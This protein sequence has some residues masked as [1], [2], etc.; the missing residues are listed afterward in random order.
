IE[1]DKTLYRPGEPFT[2]FVSSSEPEQNVTVDVLRDSS[3]IRSQ[4]IK[5]HDGRG[6]VVFTYKPEFNDR[7][8]VVAYGDSRNWGSGI[9]S[10]TILYPKPADLDVKARA[11]Q[12]NYRPGEDA[13]VNVSVRSAE[14]H[15]AESALGVVVFDSAV[16]E[17][18]RTAQEFGSPMYGPASL[19]A[20]FL[21]LEEQVAGVSLRDLSRLDMSKPISPD[22][23]LL[24]AVLLN[25]PSGFFPT[26]HGGDQYTDEPGKLFGDF[27][28]EQLKPMREA[29]QGRYA[30]TAE[31]PTNEASLRRF[32]SES[33]ID[34]DSIRDPWGTPYRPS[35]SLVQN[36]DDLTLMSAGAD[37]R[38]NTEDDFFGERLGWPYFRPTGQ[39]I[40]KAVDKYYDHTDVFIRDLVTFREA[41]TADGLNPDQMRDRWGQ[42]YRFEFNLHRSNYQISVR[43]AGP[44]QRFSAY[45]NYSHDDFVIWTSSID[46]FEKTR[47]RIE[48]ALKQN[49]KGFPDTEEELRAAL[50]G[51]RGSLETLRDP[52]RRPYYV[53]FKT[54]TL[55]VERLRVENQT[56]PGDTTSARVAFT[57]AQTVRFISVRSTGPDGKQET[58]DDFSVAILTTVLAEAVRGN[59]EMQPVGS[60]FE[61]TENSG[62]IQGVVT[63]PNGAAVAQAKVTARPSGGERTYQTTTDDNGK[64]MFHLPTGMYELQVDAPGFQSSVNKELLV[65]ASYVTEAN[66]SLQ[67]GAAAETVSVMAAGDTL[68]TTSATTTT[69]RRSVTGRGVKLVTKSGSS[70][71]ISTPRLREYFPETLVWQPS[72]ETDKQGR[73][74]INF[75]LA[76]NITTW[77]LLVVGSTEDGQLGMAEKEIRAFQPFFVE[78]DPPRV[79][80][81]G[82]EISLPV[83]VRN[84]LGRP[85]KVDLEIKPENWFSLIGAT[86][87]QISVAAGDASR[88]TF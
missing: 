18:F 3:V 22:L 8:T 34:F 50:R 60:R 14:G 13:V 65:H 5:L 71:Q 53:T 42:P 57:P 38:F 44:D 85:Q 62:W 6:S 79:L 82:D 21:G 80:T 43:S 75:K 10:H 61:V 16:E 86:R 36:S 20:R 41:M 78:H 24:A 87:K 54:E 58:G 17:R 4:R 32:L 55:P 27:V 73:A 28:K 19:V 7:L 51:T 70:D 48:G 39:M 83:T 26:F 56:N 29:L 74:R 68:S 33:K 77:K 63:D 12:D 15:L 84:Y 66:V 88:E 81:E 49:A 9:G 37:K 1:T 52:W 46:Y 67:V 11:S 64:Y 40:D 47:S 76:D 23:D 45:D 2:A 30:R 31:Y 69:E 72:I 59:A 35:F 25:E